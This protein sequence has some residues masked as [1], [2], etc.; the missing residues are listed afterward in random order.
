MLLACLP[1]LAVIYGRWQIVAP[2]VVVILM[3]PAG[4]LQAPLWV[5]YREM[6]FFK[7][8]LLQSAEPIVGL[9]VALGLAIAGA[10]YWALVLSVFI[11]AWTTAFIA[12]KASPYKLRFNYDRGAVRSYASFSWPILV[13]ALFVLLMTQAAI[14]LPN[15]HLGLAAAGSITLASTVTQF[16]DRVD[17]IVTG[18]LYPA[19]C[20]AKDRMDVLAE[21]FIKSNRIALLWAMPFG[22]A[23]SLFAGDLVHFLIGNRWIEAIGPLEIFGVTSAIGHIGFNW[24]A[25]FRATDNT[26]P[27][28]ISVGISVIVFFIV[29]VPLLYS[30]GLVGLSLGLS[31]HVLAL[32]VC[33]GYFLSKMFNG[34]GIIGHAAR[35]M[36]P[37]IPAAGVILL[38]R[39]IESG[40]RT[41]LM[42]VGELITFAVVTVAAT[43][44]FEGPLVREAMGYLRARPEQPPTAA[45]AT[46]LV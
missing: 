14:L 23:I 6:D 11:A 38:A 5:Y 26:R 28:A 21:S 3:L 2:G 24:D 15:L 9:I 4:V 34:F 25:Y 44:A 32:L 46:P 29:G 27:I 43:A 13:T 22:F 37:T 40:P 1:L 41:E 35:A 19:I 10:G 8:R 36:L 18:T 33:R 39:M 7:Q 45:P 16:T 12:I 30:N 17:Q 31:A 20:A 42:A